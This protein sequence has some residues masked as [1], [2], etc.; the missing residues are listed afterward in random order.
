DSTALPGDIVRAVAKMGTNENVAIL[1]DAT[2]PY[3]KQRG[4]DA[5]VQWN[6]ALSNQGK[7]LA[8]IWIFSKRGLVQYRN[9]S[10]LWVFGDKHTPFQNAIRMLDAQTIKRVILVTNARMTENDVA[11][12]AV[13]TPITGYCISSVCQTGMERLT[14]QLSDQRKQKG[15]S[16]AVPHTS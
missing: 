16:F 11:G 14:S 9:D 13:E 1:V 5:A 3:Q 10:S 15:E 6:L 4:L 8:T 12:A 2:D 7:P